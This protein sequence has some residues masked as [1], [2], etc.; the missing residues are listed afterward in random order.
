MKN[1]KRALSLLLS[2]MLV[3]G[4]VA[5]GGMSA[6]AEDEA[7]YDSAAPRESY[8]CRY[9]VG[10]TYGDSWYGSYIRIE[11]L[12]YTL[13]LGRVNYGGARPYEPSDPDS[14]DSGY[15]LFP[16]MCDNPDGYDI[17]V[18]WVNGGHNYDDEVIFDLSFPDGSNLHVEDPVPG[19][20]GTYHVDTTPGKS[21]DYAVFKVAAMDSMLDGWAGGAVEIYQEGRPEPFTRVVNND[22]EERSEN[23]ILLPNGYTYEFRWMKDRD[24]SECSVEV[25]DDK[26]NTCSAED[27]DAGL[28]WSFF[29]S[30]KTG[31]K[32][33]Y[34]TY[35]QSKVEDTDLIDALNALLNE[36][37]WVSYGYYSG[38][39]IWDDGQMK[40]SDFMKYQ[41][42][43]I[44]GEKYRAVTFSSFRP[45]SG[46]YAPDASESPQYE[47]GYN[48]DTVYWFRFEPIEWRVLDPDEG[49]V[50][51]NST[52]D[53]QTFNNYILGYD[54]VCYGNPE[55][56]YRANDYANSSIRTWLNDD[57]INTAFASSQQE[58]IKVTELDNSCPQ[59]A[60]YNSA[61]TNDKIFLLSYNEVTNSA[62][63]FNSD[64]DSQDD[65]RKMTPTDYAMCQGIY[66]APNGNSFWW[67]RSPLSSSYCAYGV[68]NKGC[69]TT[70]DLTLYGVCPAMRLNELKPDPTGAE[71]TD[72]STL[73]M[74]F[75][76]SW[77]Y[78]EDIEILFNIDS[79]DADGVITVYVDGKEY[80]T[81]ADDPEIT[82]PT[83]IEPE[84]DYIRV[85][86]DDP[87]SP[88]K[89]YYED[90]PDSPYIESDYVC[91]L[92]AGSYLVTAVYRSGD[93]TKTLQTT[94]MLTIA[95]VKPEINAEV[96]LSQHSGEVM[97]TS[98]T[99]S[100]VYATGEVLFVIDGIEYP[101][102]I[103]R[104][105]THFR[106]PVYMQ[107]GN[108]SLTVI[109]PGDAN[110]E[111]AA[112][113]TLFESEETKTDITVAAPDTDV[114]EKPVITVTVPG[115]EAGE[116]FILTVKDS[117][118]ETVSEE[119]YTFAAAQTGTAELDKLPAGEYT[120]EASYYLPGFPN[121]G[122]TC[123]YKAVTA[124]RVLSKTAL[125]I[126]KPDSI[127]YGDDSKLTFTLTPAGAPG[128]IK[129]FIDGEEY[130]LDSQNASL[131]LSDLNAG[132][133]MVY[134]VYEGGGDYSSAFAS[135]YITV[136]KLKP[137][138]TITQF[139][140]NIPAGENQVIKAKLSSEKATGDISIYLNGVLYHR[141]L[142]DMEELGFTTPIINY[143]GYVTIY[144][145]GDENHEFA[146]TSTLYTVEEPDDTLPPED[147]P[148]PAPGRRA[149]AAKI[150]AS[151]GETALTIKPISPVT[152]G[153]NATVELEISPATATGEIS[154]FI[155]DKEYKTDTEHLTLT[156]PTEVNP[157][158]Q[159]NLRN[160]LPEKPEHNEPVDPQYGPQPY[161][162]YVPEYYDTRYDE[163]EPNENLNKG[164]YLV[165]AEY[166]GDADNAPASAE[167]ILTVKKIQ[168]E[169]TVTMDSTIQ[170]GETLGVEVSLSS[171]RA[172][173]NCYLF[174]NGISHTVPLT[175]G[176]EGI[177]NLDRLSAG[178]YGVTVIY[179]GDRNHACAYY[180]TVIEVTDSGIMT[181]DAPDFRSDE[182]ATV[183]VSI[184][185]EYVNEGYKIATINVYDKKTGN[186]QKTSN[187]TFSGTDEE[188]GLMTATETLEALKPGEYYI[189]AVHKVKVVEGENSY[190]YDVKATASFRVYGKD[191]GFI[192]T[193][194]EDSYVGWVVNLPLTIDPDATGEIT[195]YV[196][197][198]VYTTIDA[199]NP[200]ATVSG[201]AAGRHF[202]S[203]VYTGDEEFEPCETQ[204]AE[205]TVNKNGLVFHF[206]VEPWR[207]YGD[208]QEI[209]ITLS[210]PEINGN[211]TVYIN[212]VEYHPELK[213]GVATVTTGPMLVPGT[214]D[215]VVIYEGDDKY[216][217]CIGHGSFEVGE[218]TK[219]TITFTGD[220]DSVLQS[221]EVKLN[222]NPEYTGD[223]PVKTDPDGQF[224][225]TFDGWTDEGGAHYDPD[226][227]PGVTG[228]ATYKA[229]F[230]QALKEYEI[231]FVN[232]DGTLLQKKDLA[233][234]ETP[235]YTGD[236]PAKEALEGKYTY[237]FAGWTPGIASV[238]G[239]ATYTA[240]YTEVPVNHKV[241]FKVDGEVYKELTVPY[242]KE[243]T[244][245]GNPE[246]DYYTFSGWDNDIPDTMPGN[247]LTFNALFTAIEYKATFVDENGNTVAQVPYTVESEKIDEPAVPEK[248]E[249][250]GAWEEYELTPE[251]ITVKPVYTPSDVCKLDGEYHG[252]NF[253]G[254]L[255][256]FIHNL[257]WTAFS[258]I[259]LD[260]HFSI[261]RG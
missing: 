202:I 69:A 52:I 90:M 18:S 20:L 258:F 2:L 131:S 231:K 127:T 94:K 211:L 226:N 93:G 244:A 193:A 41:D 134:A 236:T 223:T 62:Y 232:E 3:L 141:P 178:K 14:M 24:N 152:Y 106:I 121:G 125:T 198:D 26:G 242:G 144:Y 168:P 95:K 200:E 167:E 251:G 75:C 215:Y 147:T 49:I 96:G 135:D 145:P 245:P 4:T 66:K 46:G 209:G 137:E 97:M 179:E 237:D 252:D 67:L 63:G 16:A 57:F 186:L 213:D 253:W 161:C 175:G 23:D 111:F 38:T 143:A 114:N 261:K 229:S 129:V 30:Y 133:Y 222:T 8:V 153:E 65:A 118:G 31:N 171:E 146:V 128:N 73:E 91:N 81:S 108:H 207:E 35:P 32:F 177:I 224:T 230:T 192:L 53:G 17:E 48:T 25:T 157:D 163:Y 234:G 88:Y 71:L 194:P 182:T 126:T 5:L 181:V 201:L 85:D 124:L 9:R 170:F 203:A 11:Y 151:A 148:A 122:S 37:G 165:R 160:D 112:F 74:N 164:A 27:P 166:K 218:A 142:E 34:G 184:P 249:Y 80:S 180:N 15:I 60:N 21:T 99:V 190:E 68:D 7:A 183:T 50:V 246:K 220:D 235:E 87:D 189:K 241:T 76:D 130:T 6:S 104:G 155:N 216:E 256:T 117:S 84:E 119:T 83:V 172:T 1:L 102:Q 197:G 113:S 140:D 221:G 243:I 185:G 162:Y 61:T 247:D 44:E 54:G 58:N 29:A 239:T 257:I 176:A 28:L 156:I 109:Y 248:E 36:D 240:K 98:C 212:S 138:I 45:V 103:H 228:E 64:A 158:A 110:H 10:D 195:V 107:P 259:G 47:N 260:V 43:V 205:L 13:K 250:N 174:I 92:G 188:T 89:P 42:A 40:P 149:P 173:G 86:P 217:H 22:G 19:E 70:F 55:K 116:N 219:Y 169:L 227:L 59:D 105:L 56:T 12:G 159:N 79:A 123:G 154:V 233:Y 120:V 210:S 33:F 139:E 78:G 208:K 100:S 115:A 196:D 72:E 136:A 187:I 204:T 214:G 77:F 39:G 132:N 238:T 225:Y 101:A 199:A 150:A 206:D 255:V 191:P 51:C 82:I 254:K